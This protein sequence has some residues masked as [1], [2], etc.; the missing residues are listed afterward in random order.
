[1]SIDVL[2]SL[3]YMRF[4]SHRCNHCGSHEFQIQEKNNSIW[5]ECMDCGQGR[6]SLPMYGERLFDETDNRKIGDA[7]SIKKDCEDKDT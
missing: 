6:L 7:Q 4:S 1:M 2:E 3:T 5:L